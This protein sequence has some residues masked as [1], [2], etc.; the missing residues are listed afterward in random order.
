M[1]QSIG[2]NQSGY[3][4]IMFVLLLMGIGGAVTAGFTQNVK[5]SAE[6]E[7][8]L[9]NDRVLKEAKQ[10]LLMYAYRYPEI[11]LEFNGT[12]RG[13]GRLPCPDT[14]APGGAGTPNPIANCISVGGDALVGRFPWNANGMDFYDVRDASNERLWYAVSQNFANFDLDVINSDTLGT[15]TI[16]DQTGSVIYDGSVAGVAAVIIAPGLAISRGG[17]AQNRQTGA[18]QLVPANYLDLFGALDNADFINSNAANGF[19]LGPIDDLTAGTIIVNDQ[20]IL[21]TTEEVIAMAE[22]ATLQAYQKAINDYRDDLG[23]NAYPWLFD[24]SI[25]ALDTYPT[26]IPFT[27]NLTNIGR[28]PS[29]F[30]QSFVNDGVP[31]DTLPSELWIQLRFLNNTEWL[32]E[33]TAEATV[34]FDAGGSLDANLSAAYAPAPR[35]LYFWEETAVASGSEVWKLC[36]AGGNSVSD[37]N[38]DGAGNPDPFGPNL[39]ASKVREVTITYNVWAANPLPAPERTFDAIISMIAATDCTQPDNCINANSNRHAYKSA[40]YD[41]V[42]FDSLV[43]SIIYL[44]DDFY[45]AGFRDVCPTDCSNG[46][47][48]YADGGSIRIGVRYYLELPEWAKTTENNWHN[49]IQMAYSSRYRPD[50]NLTCTILADNCIKINNHGGIINDN[51]A[52]LILAGQHN[53]FDDDDNAIPIPAAAGFEDELD[54]IF[55]TTNDLIDDT[56]DVRAVNG[57]DTILAIEEL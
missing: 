20:V 19:V 38:R 21:V 41:S 18:Q 28:I 22:K 9:H 43:S 14:D 7:R 56:F 12:I 2:K 30:T 35:T 5:K 40:E 25:L 26:D 34:S 24:Y 1:N 23:V 32:N 4:L 52:I 42:I 3:M 15:I 39:T 51:V 33:F 47:M 53:L 54:D 16:H 49:S 10:A 50:T 48:A 55:D 57:N 27:N 36:P 46:T 31:G 17:V 44:Q 11:A 37:C 13:P 29:M 45:F 6:L 8:F